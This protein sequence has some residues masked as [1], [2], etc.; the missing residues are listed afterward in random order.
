M[1]TEM[2]ID[3][4]EL[5]LR[6]LDDGRWN[7]MVLAE[8]VRQHLRSTPVSPRF[9]FHGSYVSA[10]ELRS[11]SNQVKIN[12]LNLEPKPSPLLFE[13]HARA[14]VEGQTL[15]AQRRGS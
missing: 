3:S 6:R 11:A 9:S 7:A 5:L 13:A 10:A 15:E 2:R 4:P 12:E 1:P 14:G 8:A